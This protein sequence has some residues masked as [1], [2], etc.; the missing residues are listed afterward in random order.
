MGNKLVKDDYDTELLEVSNGGIG[1][2]N[3]ILYHNRRKKKIKRRPIGFL[4]NIDELV[5]DDS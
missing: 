3:H 2:Y 4:A 1:D 5:E